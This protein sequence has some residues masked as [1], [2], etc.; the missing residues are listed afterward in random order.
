MTKNIESSVQKNKQKVVVICPGRGTYN[1]EEL[2]Y[3]SKYHSDKLHILDT[4]DAHRAEQNQISIQALDSAPSY[5]LK[6]HSAG[7]NASALIY[8]CAIADFAAID[9]DKYEV[10]ALIGNSM[11]WYITLAAAGV[12]SAENAIKL[13]NTMGSLVSEKGGVSETTGQ[14]IYPIVNEN[15]KI[16]ND[17]IDLL[18]NV[19]D[20][21]SNI[22]ECEAYLSIKLGG[23]WVL[24]ANKK[25]LA[26]LEKLLPKIDQRYPMKLFNHAAF[27][28]PLLQGISKQAKAKLSQT[29]FKVPQCPI[30]DGRGHIWQPYS[31]DTDALYDYTLGHQVYDYYDFSRSVEVVLK[32]FSPDKLIVLGPGNTLGGAIGQCLVEHKWQG[33]SSKSAF[34]KRQKQDPFLLAMGNSEQRALVIK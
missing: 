30:I 3:F 24:G 10:S 21:V 6:K 19:L 17:K 2:G 20:E 11:G 32:E 8:A 9:Q 34:S 1:K 12:L 5:Q 7:E 26:K 23:Y 4:I 33:I 16:D 25:G 22:P 13:I 31:T 28:T 15:W 18:Q 14:L 29:L 27:H